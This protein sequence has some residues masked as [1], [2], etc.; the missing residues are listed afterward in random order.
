MR[1][2][3][4]GNSQRLALA[5]SGR[6]LYIDRTRAAALAE[7]DPSLGAGVSLFHGDVQVSGIRVGRCGPAESPAGRRRTD[8]RKSR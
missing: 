7:R 1:A 8:W 4:A 2:A 3:G 6:Y 5:D